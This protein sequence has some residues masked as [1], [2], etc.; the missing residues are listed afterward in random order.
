M[1]YD[2]ETQ[3]LVFASL[4]EREV[5]CP[6]C[7]KTALLMIENER[8]SLYCKNCGHSNSTIIRKS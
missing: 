4:N 7:G 8:M 3:E 2:P 1:T 6:E 5:E